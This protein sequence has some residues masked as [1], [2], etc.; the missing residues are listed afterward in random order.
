MSTLRRGL[1]RSLAPWSGV[2]GG[3]GS[4]DQY[5]DE[6]V[7][8]VDFDGADEATT[9]TDASNSAHTLV[10]GGTTKLDSARGA[11]R[12]DQ[13]TSLYVNGGSS[14]NVRV[15]DSDDFHFGSGDFTIEAD[16]YLDVAWN[17]ANN[18]LMACRDTSVG[19]QNL[20]SIDKIAG[21][22]FGSIRFIFRDGTSAKTNSIVVPV[23]I[24]PGAAEW[25]TIS[26]SRQGTSVY[27]HLDGTRIGTIDASAW[28]AMA[29]SGAPDLFIGTN[30][31]S[32]FDEWDGAIGNVR[33]TK[34]TGRYGSDDYTVSSDP[35]PTS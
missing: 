31:S 6:V 28:S 11:A 10:F 33:I 35:Y 21:G 16:V 34:G 13:V 26:I 8:L 23:G 22:S 5:F 19:G 7:L 32:S 24:A 15:N 4:G 25:H 1:S 20:W 14:D 27:V 30:T 17:A 18:F 2:G 9:E 3:G 12:T 29:A